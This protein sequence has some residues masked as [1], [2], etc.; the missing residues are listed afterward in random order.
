MFLRSLEFSAPGMAARVPLMLY[1]TSPPHPIPSPP[2]TLDKFFAEL[3]WV[4]TRL[5]V[6]R[7]VVE[8]FYRHFGVSR[9]FVENF[10]GR[11][12]CDTTGKSAG[13][14]FDENAA[15]PKMARKM[16]GNMAANPKTGANPSQI[17]PADP[18]LNL[19]HCQKARGP[20]KGP[21]DPLKGPRGPFKMTLGSF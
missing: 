16:L 7:H 18:F 5:G 6:R 11:L 2:P 9:A 21:R 15:N 4:R 17:S 12:P 19:S 8:H 3:A 10:S 13:K 1:A 20:F 14:I